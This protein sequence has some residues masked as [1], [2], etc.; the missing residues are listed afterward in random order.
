MVTAPPWES[1]RYRHF[2]SSLLNHIVRKQQQQD[3]CILPPTEPLPS[4]GNEAFST[5]TVVSGVDDDFEGWGS[6]TSRHGRHQPRQSRYSEG[7]CSSEGRAR[8]EEDTQVRHVV[9]T[10][11][12]SR[13]NSNNTTNTNYNS[14]YRWHH[15]RLVP[16]P[17]PALV[18]QIEHEIDRSSA[19]QHRRIYTTVLHRCEMEQQQR[20]SLSY[21]RN[22]LCRE[23]SS[24]MS[25]SSLPS[26]RESQS[27]IPGGHVANSNHHRG[28]S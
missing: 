11:S 23:S 17:D 16:P 14:Y 12:H 8:R 7:Y 20:A 4:Q 28:M 22:S 9:T 10:P 1:S 24:L 26:M 6:S 2:L 19:A 25:P 18:Q 21:G 5:R 13:G 27:T 3:S 15:P